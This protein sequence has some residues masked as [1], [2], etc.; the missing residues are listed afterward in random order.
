MPT[1]NPPIWHPYPTHTTS[2]SINMEFG[3][4]DTTKNYGV[5]R[6]LKATALVLA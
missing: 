1:Q 6:T 3:G 4:Y 2:L 5:V